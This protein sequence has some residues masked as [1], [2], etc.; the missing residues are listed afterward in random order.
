MTCTQTD[1][2]FREQK[3]KLNEPFFSLADS[4]ASTQSVHSI[5]QLAMGFGKR[6]TND[7]LTAAASGLVP[8]ESTRSFND[9][10]SAETPEQAKK[11]IMT[12]VRHEIHRERSASESNQEEMIV[13][14]MD[15]DDL[16]AKPSIV[17]INRMTRK[18]T[19]LLAGPKFRFH[20][21]DPE[22]QFKR[23]TVYPV[24]VRELSLCPEQSPMDL[25][26]QAAVGFVTILVT[27]WKPISSFLSGFFVGF[28]IIAAIAYILTRFYMN[29]KADETVVHEWID[30]PELDAM[31]VSKTPKEDKHTTLHVGI[32]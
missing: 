25:F 22:I 24:S 10:F 17:P 2:C 29:A 6:P 31:H 18:E 16:T 9:L 4:N 27:L 19:L 14:N 13:N 26:A 21:V 12:G 11:M 23:E 20:T 1:L 5:S 30:F 15:P 7:T 3:R 32:S 28:L 8:S